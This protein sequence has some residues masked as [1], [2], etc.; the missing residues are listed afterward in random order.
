[1]KTLFLTTIMVLSFV[2]IG[3]ANPVY[4]TNGEVVNHA[5]LKIVN[6]SNMKEANEYA[7]KVDGQVFKEQGQ[8]L[9]RVIYGN[10]K[11]N[12]VLILT[13]IE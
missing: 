13:S 5:S 3:L 2:S 1:M 10:M 12:D 7:S 9:Y 11:I 8:E 4:K 6:F